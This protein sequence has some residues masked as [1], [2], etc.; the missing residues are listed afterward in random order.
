MSLS[1]EVLIYIQSVKEFFKKN[2]NTRKYFL[3]NSNEELFFKHLTEISEKNHNDTGDPMLNQDQ[4]ELLRKTILAI[5]LATSDDIPVKKFE[6][7]DE[8]FDYDN[9]AFIE[10]LP[11]FGLVCLN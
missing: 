6:F 8:D 7:K 10:L 9:R 4:F 5:T 3:E 11:N 2:D 1:P